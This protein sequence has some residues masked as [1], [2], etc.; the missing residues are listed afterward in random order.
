MAG[1]VVSG[2]LAATVPASADSSP[3]YNVYVGYADTLRPAAA[4]FP[5]PFNSKPGV[6]NESLPSDAGLDGGAI[7]VVNATAVTENVD[8]VTVSLGPCTFDLWPH[9]VALPFADQLVLG[10]TATGGGE[11]A[12]P[13]SPPDRPFSTLPTSARTEPTGPATARSHTSSPS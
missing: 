2:L 5:T 4:N 13:A 1:L 3:G 11:A 6:I 7:R 8:Y 12:R 9:N 10:P